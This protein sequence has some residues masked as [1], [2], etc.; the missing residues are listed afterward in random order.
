MVLQVVSLK[1]TETVTGNTGGTLK[2]IEW[3]SGVVK[4]IVRFYGLFSMKL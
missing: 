3:S 1:V 2:S 4:F